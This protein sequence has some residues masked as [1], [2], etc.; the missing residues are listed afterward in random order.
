MPVGFSAFTT[1]ERY[2]NDGDVV[3]F[4]GVSSNFGGYFNL[5]TG[6]FVCPYWG[7]YWFSVT[8]RGG[9]SNSCNA[10]ITVDGSYKAQVHGWVSEKIN[11][12]AVSIVVECKVGQSVWIQNNGDNRYYNG[13]DKTNVFSGYLLHKY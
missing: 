1:L 5:E 3:L 10:L 7:V 6:I 4:D 11:Q 13:A 9:T 8:C 12:A 2:Y